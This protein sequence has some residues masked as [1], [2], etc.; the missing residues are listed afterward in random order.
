[1][2]GG[3]SVASNVAVFTGDKQ[4]ISTTYLPNLDDAYTFE[5]WFWDDVSGIFNPSG[6]NPGTALISNYSAS[7]TPF[8]LVHISST[9]VVNAGERNSTGVVK[10]VGGGPSIVTGQWVHVVSS[11]TATL[12]TLYVNGVRV[13]SVDRPGGS[14]TS[15]NSIVIGG[16]HLGRYQT[17]RL[18]PVRIYHDKALTGAEVSQN[19][20]AER[21]STHLAVDAPLVSVTTPVV[22]ETSNIVTEKLALHIDP[23]AA[24]SYPGSGTTL[25]DLSG[26]GR[27]CTL[28]GGAR[29][30]GNVVVLNGHPQY[31]STTYQPN[32]DDNRAYTFELWFWD[33]NPGIPGT[34]NTALI[35]N[36]MGKDA[37]QS[38]S[39]HI[40][41]NGIPSS[42]ECNS[43]GVSGASLLGPSIATGQWVHLV[44]SAT[45]AE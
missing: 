19:Y 18:G 28:K 16:N 6:N 2:E 4:Y 41:W 43:T 30:T 8:A 5:L 42:N 1:L 22:G 10:G 20:N 33:D 7:T 32:L 37:V 39:L 27:T 21:G 44:L 31:I 26:N 9:G 34:S 36:Y 12:L 35:S 14:V 45:A 11:A 38:A 17:C 24:A 25:L 23:S 29:V 40:D 13:G 15:T 3:A